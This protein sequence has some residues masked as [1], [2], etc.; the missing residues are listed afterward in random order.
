[1]TV[2]DEVAALDLLVFAI[3]DTRYGLPA[4]EVVELTRAVA[5]S[6]RPDAEQSHLLE[7]VVNLHGQLAAAINLRSRFGHPAKRLSP[8]EHFIFTRA[9]G[10]LLA[11][12]ADHIVE[13]I[14]TPQDSLDMIP[15][16]TKDKRSEAFAGVCK[17]SENLIFIFDLPKFLSASDSRS[18]Q[19][20]LSKAQEEEG[21]L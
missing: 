16:Q 20:L 19:D 6:S 11:L 12:R 5:I 1:M 9:S 13:I 3:D 17:L 4:S 18:I 14:R 15:R 21:Q 2:L 7:G 8:S 10:H